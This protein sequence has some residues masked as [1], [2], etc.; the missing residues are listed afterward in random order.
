MPCRRRGRT[1]GSG[2][3]GLPPTRGGLRTPSGESGLPAPAPGAPGGP[4]SGSLANPSVHLR[5]DHGTRC[6]EG[7]WPRWIRTTIPRSKVWCP[8]VG[9][10]A[11]DYDALELSGGGTGAGASDF[12]ATLPLS[13]Q[14]RLAGMKPLDLWGFDSRAGS[15]AAYLG[16]VGDLFDLGLLDEARWLDPQD[17]VRLHL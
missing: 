14:L 9:R 5:M 8:A 6:R 2:E 17:I 16:A 7:N 4:P 1:P 3:T 10:G 13:H 15:I 11:S 12:P